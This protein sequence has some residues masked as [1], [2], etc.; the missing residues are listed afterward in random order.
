MKHIARRLA[1]LASCFLISASVHA[2]QKVGIIQPELRAPFKII[3]DSIGDG[4]DKKI[5]KRSSRLVLNKNYRP[6]DISR[7]LQS[8]N[9]DAVITL[10][11]RGQKASI[12]VP[13]NMPV[14]LGAL[15]SA[16]APTN[17]H[18]GL[19]LTSDPKAMF[20]LL[21]NLDKL[22][23]KIMVVYNPLKSQWLIDIAKRQA[24]NIGVRLVGYKATDLKQAAIIYNEILSGD[25]LDKTALWLLQDR[26]VVDSKIVL[27]FILEKSWQKDMIVFSSALGHV[28]KGVLFAM[29]PD[30]NLHGEQLA[31]M[32]LK[33]RSGAS[34]KNKILPSKNVQKAI[35]S[36]TAEHLGINLSKSELRNY[37]VVF[38]V[39]N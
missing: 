9:I 39:S 20:K 36:R 14:V 18:P 7:W 16:P 29:Y 30:N 6:A 2:E 31:E 17:P 27:P 28:N 22:R 35:N 1:A 12:Y 26:T 32:L 21:T 10:G 34:S 4:V 38:P 11:S 25:G 5:G 13:K 33:L 24:A 8:E 15:L 3:F 37:D 19:A 23:K